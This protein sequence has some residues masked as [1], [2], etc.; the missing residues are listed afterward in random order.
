MSS[1]RRMVFRPLKDEYKVIIIRATQLEQFMWWIKYPELEA[2]RQKFIFALGTCF[3]NI[4]HCITHEQDY[5]HH[6]EE[7]ENISYDDRSQKEAARMIGNVNNYKEYAKDYIGKISDY[8]KTLRVEIECSWYLVIFQW[9]IDAILEDG[10]LLDYKTAWQLYTENDVDNKKQ[11][12]YYPFLKNAVD[13]TWV[14]IS[15]IYFVC[16]KQKKS[17]HKTYTRTISYKDALRDT[18][19]HMKIYLTAIATGLEHSETIFNSY[20]EAN[21]YIEKTAYDNKKWVFA[22]YSAD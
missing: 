1:T 6:I 15:F 19:Q 7:L 17:N 18:K 8:E 9:T 5:S 21:E 16:T 10:N 2:D 14:D 3:H 13:E 4:M 12:I 11:W 20:K 22:D